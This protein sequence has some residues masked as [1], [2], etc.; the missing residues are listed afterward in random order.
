MFKD[1]VEDVFRFLGDLK[2]N[3]KT[4]EVF[5]NGKWTKTKWQY[6]VTGDILRINNMDMFPC[7]L[8]LFDSSDSNGSC[9]VETS[10]LDGES[11]L[12]FRRVPDL[13]FEVFKNTKLENFQCEIICDPPNTDVHFFNGNLIHKENTQSLDNENVLLRGSSLRNTD[14]VIGGAIYC[15]KKSK[16]F[17]N[18]K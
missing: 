6:V 15:G 18:R 13:A 12:K 16:L 7:D 10:G 14:W 1:F 9:F 11:D 4:C 3:L 17:Q 2:I 8:I 5:R